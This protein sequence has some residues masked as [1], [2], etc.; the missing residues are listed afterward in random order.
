MRTS[1]AIFLFF[2]LF[3][4]SLSSAETVF[5]LHGKIVEDQGDL[6]NHPQHGIYRYSDIV[7]ALAKAGHRIV[8]EIRPKGTAR[9]EYAQKIVTQINK[10]IASGVEP[11]EIVVVGFSKGAQIATLVSGML[12]QEDVRFV[13][14]AVCG[15]WIRNRPTL[16]LVGDIHSMY[17]E[18]DAA[19]TCADLFRRSGIEGCETNLNTGLSHGLFF[20][21]R[22]VWLKPML[23]WIN[24]GTCPSTHAEGM[25][26]DSEGQK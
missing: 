6:A 20:Q 15:N 21:P 16:K 24:T 8:S 2:A 23:S 22:Q 3:Y 1:K 13:I 9:V 17:E 12:N 25:T 4:A 7:S 19:L 10:L 18:S 14:Q 26:N 5:Y 11:R